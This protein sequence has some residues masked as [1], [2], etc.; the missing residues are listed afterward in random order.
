MIAGLIIG[1]VGSLH[2]VG[3]CGPLTLFVMGKNSSPKIF[4]QYHT[5]RIAT[6]ILLGIILG[7]IGHTLQLFQVQQIVAL[8]LGVTLLL[9]YSLPKL[10]KRLEH[11][12]YQSRSYQS[13]KQ[14]LS[15]NLSGRNRVILSGVY[16]GFI[17]CGLTY[18]AAATAV[19]TANF[20]KG[21]LFM[22]FF[23]MGTLPALFMVAFS[24]ALFFQKFKLIIPSAVSLTA[25]VSGCLLIV[26]GLLIS[27]PDFTQFIQAKAIGLI[28]VCGF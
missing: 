11:F 6:Y 17:P 26:R 21:I 27:S 16:N 24:G 18:V 13:I 7:F 1:F 23:G 10:R 9:L 5:G 28:T 25:I 2:C 3:M 22:F 15:R 12:Y 8:S 4:L 19:A 20:G 14:R